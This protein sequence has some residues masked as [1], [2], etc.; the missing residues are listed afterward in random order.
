MRYAIGVFIGA[1]GHLSTSSDPLNAVA[2]DGNAVL[3]ARSTNLYYHTNAEERGRMFPI[4]PTSSAGRTHVTSGVSTQRRKDFRRDVADRDGK[5]CL[6]SE[7]EEM[8]CDAVHILSHSKG[9]AVHTLCF[10]SIYPSSLS[11]LW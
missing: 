3:P 10:L 8:F 9:D 1:Q 5:R 7:V 11:Q 4:D 6:L 2:V